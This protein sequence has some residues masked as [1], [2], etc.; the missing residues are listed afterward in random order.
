VAPRRITEKAEKYR[1]K[2]GLLPDYQM[3]P[4]AYSDRCSA[5]KYKPV[6]RKKD[7]NPGSDTQGRA[8]EAEPETQTT[9]LSA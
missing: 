3:V 5:N 9:G 4:E 7:P 6:P 8:A 2:W 1:E